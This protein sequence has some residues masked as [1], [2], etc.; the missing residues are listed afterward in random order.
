MTYAN[1]TTAKAQLSK[2]IADVEKGKTV[3][4]TK[5]GKPTEVLTKYSKSKP[6]RKKGILK[7]A[8]KIAKDFNKTSKH[9]IDS[10]Y[11]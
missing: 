6:Y 11:H 7:G 5:A 4:I 10:F 2:Y 3:V 9:I 8:I 1:I